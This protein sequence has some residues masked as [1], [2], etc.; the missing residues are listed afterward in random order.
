MRRGREIER[1][2]G[3]LREP[4][5][6]RNDVGLLGVD[7][8]LRREGRA[9]VA[10]EHDAPAIHHD[11]ARNLVGE[12]VDAMLDHDDRRPELLVET[13]E[14][15]ED[16][17]HCRP[18]RD[19]RSARRAPA[20]RG[21]AAS[22]AAMLTRCFWP[23]E[24]SK[25][26]RSPKPESPTKPSASAW[27]VR[28]SAVGRQRF[29]RPKQTSSRTRLLM[30]CASGSW[31]TIPTSV[32]NSTTLVSAIV[33]PQTLA[34]AGQRAVDQMRGGAVEHVQ[35]RALA[36]AARAENQHEFAAVDRQRKL[37]RT[38]TLSPS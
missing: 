34:A 20:G 22:T 6:D 9:R 27:R 37:V 25:I 21:C 12:F 3:H 28:I 4:A 35:Q 7:D 33:L 36:A 15:R 31:N 16:F 10:V 32:A 29:S 17:G 30:I 38:G 14:H 1:E 19:W 5:G 8:A 11:H 13:R 23:P 2:F 18:D 24:S 26:E